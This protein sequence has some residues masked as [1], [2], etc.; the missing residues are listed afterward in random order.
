MGR[1]GSRASCWCAGRGSSSATSRDE[2]GDPLVRDADGHGWFPTGDVATIDADGYMQITDRSKDVIK[3]GGEWIGSIDLENIAMAHP[4]VAMAACIAAQHPKWDERPLLVVVKKPG[5]E[6][7]ARRADRVLRRPDRQVVDARRRGLRRRDPARRDRQ[8][9]EEPAAR[10]VRQAPAREGLIVAP[11]PTRA[12]AGVRAAAIG[13]VWWGFFPLY[14]RLV[15]S[16]SPPEVLAQP[17]RLVAAAAAGVVLTWR[18]PV[19]VAR[20]GAARSRRV[21]ASFAASALL[22]SVN[23]MTYIWAVVERPRR[24]RQPGLLHD[25]ARQRRARLLRAAR[26]AAARAVDRARRWPRSAS[27]G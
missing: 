16:A 21:L 1:Q 19:G 24:R 7:D 12:G 17:D 25:A 6:L 9:A 10:A 20:P 18:A 23:W 11:M 14:F 27:P 13:F 15:P 22:L 4:T 26:A 5:A 8:D 2:G 3:S